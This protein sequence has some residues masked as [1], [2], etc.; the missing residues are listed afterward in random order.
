MIKIAE[1]EASERLAP[2]SPEVSIAGKPSR[3]QQ[4]IIDHLVHTLYGAEPE[5]NV[6]TELDQEAAAAIDNFTQTPPLEGHNIDWYSPE[7]VHEQ[8][9]IT[10]LPEEA[11]HSHPAVQEQINAALPQTRVILTGE[12]TGWASGGSGGWEATPLGNGVY[13][14]RGKA[15]K[16]DPYKQYAYNPDLPCQELAKVLEQAGIAKPGVDGHSAWFFKGGHRGGST[17]N[18]NW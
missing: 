17:E 5:G 4:K 18:D 1:T 9:H 16:G 8:L 14:V 15:V 13:A 6:A 11:V 7:A 12:H 3:A 10:V 2:P